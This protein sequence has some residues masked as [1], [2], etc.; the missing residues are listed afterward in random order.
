[1]G[2]MPARLMSPSVG[3]NPTRPQCDAGETMEPSV[4]V[5]MA[6]AQRL[7]ATAA[8]EPEL[9]PEGLRFNRYGLRVCPPRPLH[10]LIERLPRK[11]AHSLSFVLPRSTTSAS[12]SVGVTVASCRGCE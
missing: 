9:D 5:P 6:N 10:P 1:M 4:S 2:M 3:F 8:A 12:R 7:A 11:F